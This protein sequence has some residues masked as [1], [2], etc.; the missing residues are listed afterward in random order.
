MRWLLLLVWG[1]LLL[2][3][4]RSSTLSP[5]ESGAR[6]AVTQGGR[7][8]IPDGVHKYSYGRFSLGELKDGRFTVKQTYQYSRYGAVRQI[9]VLGDWD[10]DGEDTIGAYEQAGLFQL[11][12]YNTSTDN[13]S[14]SL[15]FGSPQYQ[16][17]MQRNVFGE[18]SLDQIPLA[19]DWDGDGD[20]T[21]GLFI[22]SQ[23]RFQLR[24]SN[25][26][27]YADLDFTYGRSG[28][29]PLVGDW[30]GDGKTTVGLYDPTSGYYFLK[31]TNAGGIADIVFQFGA[32]H[33]IY[34]TPFRAIAGDWNGDGIDTV[35]FY[36]PYNGKLYLKNTN[37]P[38]PADEVYQFDLGHNDQ[39]VVGQMRPCN[40][41]RV[42]GGCWYMGADGQSCNQVCANQGGYSEL[43]R[44][45]AGSEGSLAVCGNVFNA[46]RG[47]GRCATGN[48][49]PNRANTSNNV[50]YNI[51]GGPE[52]LGTGCSFY[53]YQFVTGYTP[54]PERYVLHYTGYRTT[55]T[56]ARKDFKRMCSC[57]F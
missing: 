44:I 49:E 55:P 15:Y 25:T 29:Q 37:T 38:G 47:Q 35:G 4:D 39:L 42:S 53:S 7:R 9:P 27:G 33:P 21:V 45:L 26:P 8:F 43:T 46:I 2:G 14:G 3:C 41:A 16:T 6:L 54:F 51:W 32:G 1:I 56:A 12:H 22:L 11:A 18:Y 48:C 19:G 24:N 17:V 20:E 13:P 50:P 36:N 10:G 30:N 40:G 23:N 34:E 57:N 31:N 28:M 52:Y 5:S